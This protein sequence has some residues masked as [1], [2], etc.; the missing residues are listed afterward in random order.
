MEIDFTSQKDRIKYIVPYGSK[1]LSTPIK[2]CDLQFSKG[3][4]VDAIWD[5]GS[6]HSY[7]SS[8]VVVSLGLDVRGR[9]M[10]TGI[11]GRM[12][13]SMSFAIAFPGNADWYT[14]SR[15]IVGNVPVDAKFIIGLDI[16][17]MGDLSL[18]HLDSGTLLEFVFEQDYFVNLNNDSAKT[19]F[20][21]MN[22]ANERLKGTF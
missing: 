9:G 20:E 4:I 15:P 17:T 12:P 18:R 2:L 14:I 1:Y 3:I 13:V 22:K 21:K 7:I 19:A 5:T 6:T 10:V 16:I 11:G 8:D